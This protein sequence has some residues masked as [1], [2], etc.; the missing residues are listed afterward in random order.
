M[1]ETNVVKY[2]ERGVADGGTVGLPRKMTR[3]MVAGGI[4]GMG[5]LSQL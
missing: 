4:P 1:S 3:E 2:D 5:D